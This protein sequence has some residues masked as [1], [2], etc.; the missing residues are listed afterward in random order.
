VPFDVVSVPPT[1]VVPE[2]V[3]GLTTVGAVDPPVD[4]PPPPPLDGGAV[5]TAVGEE[6]AT[7]EPFL[8]D[9]VT[10]TA[11]V[12]PT[13]SAESEYVVAVAPSMGAQ[14]APHRCH[15]IWKV[16]CGPLQL[17]VVAVSV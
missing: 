8:F 2:I 10:A 6:V 12:E 15:W 4:P 14:L 16:A 17:P 13:S 1:T 9:A 3:P 11:I 7:A 5:T